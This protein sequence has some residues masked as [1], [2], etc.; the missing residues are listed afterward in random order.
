MVKTP[1]LI[2]PRSPR[3]VVEDPDAMF[4]DLYN[5]KTLPPSLKRD[6]RRKMRRRSTIYCLPT[7]NSR[8]VELKQFY[9]ETRE[10]IQSHHRIFKACLKKDNDAGLFKTLSQLQRFYL[11]AK[12]RMQRA[13]R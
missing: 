1:I 10:M 9:Q 2:N 6:Y 8:F 5:L 12:H 4:W 11:N 13:N 7:G 3:R